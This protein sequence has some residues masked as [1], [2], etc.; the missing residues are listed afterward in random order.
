MPEYFILLDFL[1]L[2]SDVETI[3]EIVYGKKKSLVVDYRSKM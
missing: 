2:L 1:I 3:S